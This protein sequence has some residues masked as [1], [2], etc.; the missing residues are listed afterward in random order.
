MSDGTVTCW[1][2]NAIGQLGMGS[3]GQVYRAYA[4]PVMFG[5]DTLVDATALAGGYYFN[6]A[7]LKNG[8]VVC[9]GTNDQGQIGDGTTTERDSPTLVAFY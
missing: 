6:C 2:R 3:S 9:W 8:N 5:S 1:A 7:L 4:K